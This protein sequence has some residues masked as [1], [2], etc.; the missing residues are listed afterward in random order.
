MKTRA[1]SVF[2]V[3]IFID[4]M[5]LKCLVC[6]RDNQNSCT[7]SKGPCKTTD[8]CSLSSATY[9]GSAMVASDREW[10]ERRIVTDAPRSPLGFFTTVVHAS[11]GDPVNGSGGGSF[12]PPVSWMREEPVLVGALGAVYPASK[13]LDGFDNGSSVEDEVLAEL[14]GGIRMPSNMAE[15]TNCTVATD[16]A[17]WSPIGLSPQLRLVELVWLAEQRS[18]AEVQSLNWCTTGLFRSKCPC[19][20]W[21]VVL[22]SWYPVVVEHGDVHTSHARRGEYCRPHRRD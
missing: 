11:L 2:Q 22:E 14:S 1:S 5:A 17:R 9:H 16:F 18:E 20:P 12:C 13:M 19:W 8:S 7:P 15:F 21:Q 4:V 3:R 6:W 10:R